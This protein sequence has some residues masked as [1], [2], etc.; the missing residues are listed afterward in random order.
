MTTTA[1]WLCCDRGTADR[2]GSLGEAPL[3]RVAGA[4]R[5]LR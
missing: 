4:F 2:E 3:E 1:T 5:V